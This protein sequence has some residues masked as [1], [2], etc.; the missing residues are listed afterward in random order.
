VTAPPTAASAVR[1][2]PGPLVWLFPE[3]AAAAGDDGAAFDDAVA[4]GAQALLVPTGPLGRTLRRALVQRLRGTSRTAWFDADRPGLEQ[5]LAEAALAAGPG[6]VLELQPDGAPVATRGDWPAFARRRAAL[7]APLPWLLPLHPGADLAAQ[8]QRALDAAAR[9]GDVLRRAPPVPFFV[10]DPAPAPA[11]LATTRLCES[12]FGLLPGDAAPP[13][14]R[15]LAHELLARL[16]PDRVPLYR[17]LENCALGGFDLYLETLL[18]RA[19]APA[20]AP[21]ARWPLLLGFCGI[22]G[23]GKSSQL[24]ALGDWLRA[25]GLRVAVVKFYRHGVFHATVTDVARRCAGGR[26]L[27]LWR[28]ERLAKLMDSCKCAPAIERVLAQHDVVLFDRSIWTHWA[29]GA[30]RSHHDP[31]AR[32]LTAGLPVPHRTFL[33]DLPVATAVARLGGRGERTIDENEYMLSRYRELLLGLAQ[34][35]GFQVLD[36]EAPFADNQAAVRAEVERLLL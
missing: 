22:D 16:W 12:W 7:A 3:L 2:P 9:G 8:L 20:T 14:V 25:R 29:A 31:F 4:G 35:H 11:A 28:L 26:V 23:S 1:V 33:L 5:R 27:G 10:T 17:A 30:G 21:A 19:L 36:A 15:A 24:Q 32:E 34:Q 13:T 6:C 18:G